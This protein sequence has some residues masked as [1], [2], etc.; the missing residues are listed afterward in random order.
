MRIN[1]TPEVNEQLRVKSAKFHYDSKIYESLDEMAVDGTDEQEFVIGLDFGTSFTKVAIRH[2]D[3]ERAWAIP[4]T[5]N[6]DNRYIIS[7]AVYK[8]KDKYS[9]MS[10]GQEFNNLKTSLILG[11]STKEERI[12]AAIFLS[13]IIHHS[14]KW[15]M[16]ETKDVFPDVLPIWYLHIGLPA[17]S[18]N[19]KDLV[20]NYRVITMSAMVIADFFEMSVSEAD[21]EQIY[22]LIE[23]WYTNTGVEDSVNLGGEEYYKDQL[24]IIPEI[25]AQVYGYVKSDSWDK[26]N[27]KIMLVDI[28]GGTLDA[29]IFNVTV[30]KRSEH[31]FHFQRSCVEPFGAFNLHMGRLQH[32]INLFQNREGLEVVKKDFDLLIESNRSPMLY[33]KLL[34]NML[35]M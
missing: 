35:G 21:A 32:L 23:E 33:R 12:R 10:R 13:M 15:F 34:K 27:P 18:L 6:I 1:G 26:K 24:E 8:S 19:N 5:T 29:S 11:Q 20:L 22:S 31:N 28:G 7:S 17:K 16:N 14:K 4:F 3:T 9:L 25:A 2:E 30:E